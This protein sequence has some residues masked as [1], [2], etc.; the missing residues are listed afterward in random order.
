MT[1]PTLYVFIFSWI[2]DFDLL[3][4]D[5]TVHAIFCL[6][7]LVNFLWT[8]TLNGMTSLFLFVIIMCGLVF[9][10]IVFMLT[11]FFYLDL[12]VRLPFLWLFYNPF[13]YFYLAIWVMG[14][15][16]LGIIIIF[17]SLVQKKLNFVPDKNY[18]IA[19]NSFNV[20]GALL[21]RGWWGH[22]KWP[23]LS[24]PEIRVSEDTQKGVQ[25]MDAKT[26]LLLLIILVLEIMAHVKRWTSTVQLYN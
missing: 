5:Y 14:N 1:L 10:G 13:Q 18:F 6:W 17:I 12:S 24:F 16:V 23:W 2:V 25:Q 21:C 4:L 19:M 8:I 20:L 22:K 7:L 15:C 3:F 9:P 26:T 11:F